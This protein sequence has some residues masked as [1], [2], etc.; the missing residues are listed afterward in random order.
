MPCNQA[1]QSNNYCEV[2]FAL[3]CCDIHIVGCEANAF[4]SSL[5]KHSFVIPLVLVR[6][7]RSLLHFFRIA[8]LL[9]GKGAGKN[10]RFQGKANKMQKRAEA[11]A[12]IRSHLSS[13]ETALSK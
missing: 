1:F 3:N 13:G 10:G 8:E 12:L 7:F 6:F 5:I 2:V 11:E 4:D 9:D